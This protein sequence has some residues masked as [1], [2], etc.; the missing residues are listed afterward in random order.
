MPQNLD[1]CIWTV[2]PMRP[3]QLLLRACQF[4]AKGDLKAKEWANLRCFENSTSD[5]DRLSE[6]EILLDELKKLID[7][8]DIPLSVSQSRSFS[9][10]ASSPILLDSSSCDKNS[11]SAL[12]MRVKT[13]GQSFD[14]S[15]GRRYEMQPD[16][17]IRIEEFPS[18]SLSPFSI[19]SMTDPQ[20]QEKLE[21]ANR[22]SA[23]LQA[24]VDF[25]DPLVVKVFCFSELYFPFNSCCI[26]YKTDLAL[27]QDYRFLADLVNKGLPAYNIPPCKDWTSD[28]MYTFLH[29]CRTDEGRTKIWNWL[30]SN[31]IRFRN[32]NKQVV[33]KFLSKGLVPVNNDK[34]FIFSTETPPVGGFVSDLFLNF[35]SY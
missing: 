35:T 5:Y 22:L 9:I 10:A 1:F 32:V 25:F 26:Y 6:G 21:N 7:C 15:I 2:K 33:N 34:S 20:L 19:P 8:I 3:E 18:R 16:L 4:S 12:T 29:E 13:F 28:E 11:S 17:L 24:I 14:A 31:D 27:I 30:V 23:L